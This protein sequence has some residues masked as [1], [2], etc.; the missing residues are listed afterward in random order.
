MSSFAAG[1][2]QPALTGVRGIGDLR[3]VSSRYTGGEGG[4]PGGGVVLTTRNG[5]RGGVCALTR[6]S[7]S[8]LPGRDGGIR[9]LARELLGERCSTCTGVGCATGT[10]TGWIGVG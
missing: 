7:R 4:S 6:R 10:G 1:S 9:D 3:D 8:L 5:R 2:G